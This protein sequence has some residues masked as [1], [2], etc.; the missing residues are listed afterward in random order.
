[1]TLCFLREVNMKRKIFLTSLIVAGVSLSA[2]ASCGHDVKLAESDAPDGLPKVEVT[3]ESAS[4]GE[5]GNTT[6]AAENKNDDT[7]TT[8]AGVTTERTPFVAGG[9]GAV[10]TDPDAN[11]N[12]SGGGNS[13]GGSGNGGG[14]SGGNT[15]SGNSVP[16]SITLSYY[17]AEILVGQTKQYPKVSENIK[18]V[19]TSS[20]ESVATVDSIGNITGRGAGECIIRVAS[21]SDPDLKAEVKVTVKQQD[22]VQ[23]VDG[24]TY[25]KGMLIANKS[26][27][28]PSTYNPG[29]LTGET[30]SAFQ[31]LVL[32]AA[33][34]GLTIYNSS[35]FRS[36]ETQNQI[37][38]NY[39][40]NYGQASA[41]TFSA[42]PGY[43]EHQS[44]LAIDCN[45]IDDSFIGTPEAIWLENHCTEYGFII[46]YPQ[47]K[48]GITGYKYEPWHI[49]Y[50]GKENARLIKEAAEAA[51]DPYLTLEEYLGIDSYYH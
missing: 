48:Q 10:G 20:D 30:Y 41:D 43:S 44:G 25:I 7:E 29:G 49:R 11:G 15:A 18:E 27:A 14:N 22:G 36:Y 35:G 17:S 23:V 46:R 13:G 38:N 9:N 31:E 2:L 1:M 12:S 21:A 19:W 47:G 26:Y 16:K 50:V 4:S 37:Y 33:N 32:G 51:G 39:V 45:I 6:A 40:A 8:T 24:I 42:R 34:D 5:A 3:T 28:L